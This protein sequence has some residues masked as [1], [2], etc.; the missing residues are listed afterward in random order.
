MAERHTCQNPARW[1]GKVRI[2]GDDLIVGIPLVRVRDGIR[3]DVPAIAGV[4][5]RIERPEKL[6]CIAPS[7]PPP[8]E[9]S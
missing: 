1:R 9:Y 4:P 2:A 7:V 8:F 6:V 3:L 5:V